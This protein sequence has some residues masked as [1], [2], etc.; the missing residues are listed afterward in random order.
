MRSWTLSQKCN[1]LWGDT[2]GL[3]LY[4]RF[5]EAHL[6]GIGHPRWKWR[7]GWKR[8]S[9]RRAEAADWPGID[10]HTKVYPGGERIR[11]EGP[12][13]LACNVWKTVNCKEWKRLLLYFRLRWPF[14][15][16]AFRSVIDC[17]NSLFILQSEIQPGQI[18]LG[19]IVN[20][21]GI[22]I[23]VGRKL[24]SELKNGRLFCL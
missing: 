23:P 5:R 24:V 16:S 1:L 11:R 8:K 17:R 14:F 7:C 4:P 21:E 18:C 3:H 6:P 15:P 19:W 12:R 2:R 10:R 20:G 9:L 22:G 13:R